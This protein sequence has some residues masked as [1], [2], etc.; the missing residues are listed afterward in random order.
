M[1]NV[2]AIN[3]SLSGENSKS[4]Q[5]VKQFI[6]NWKNNSELVVNERDLAK[7]NIPHLSGEEMQAWMTE[8]TQRSEHQVELA[9]LSDNY[10]KEVQDADI[11]VVGMPMYNFGVPSVFK[12]W[13]DRI[14]RAGI[15]FRYTE[16]GPLG[17]LENKTVY[18]LATRGGIYAGTEKDSQ[19]QYIK[20]VF[21]F[22]GLTDVQF[23]YAEGLALPEAPATNNFV[24]AEEKIVELI[25]KY[26]A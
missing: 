17:L 15:T 16:N 4:Q 23:I 2:L 20:D 12:A 1:K 25:A 26:A 9:S 21:A 11:L 24:Q 3:T 13:I 10:I 19:T 8:T 5:L 18:V 22:V 6:G 14:A 7:D